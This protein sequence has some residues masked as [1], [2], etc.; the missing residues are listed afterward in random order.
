MLN[1]VQEKSLGSLDLSKKISSIRPL[2]AVFIVSLLLG[3]CS[4]NNNPPTAQSQQKTVDLIISAANSIV[5]PIREIEELYEQQKPEVDVILNLANSGALQQQ[6]EQGAPADVF[7]SSAA[8]KMDRL[9]S[10]QLLLSGSR[11]N[12]LQ[13]KVAL[14]VPSDSDVSSFQ[15]LTDE[16]VERISIGE[17]TSSPIGSYS[18]EVFKSQT[19]NEQIKPKLVFGKHSRQVLEYVRSGSADAGITFTT[20]VKPNNEQIKIAAVAE[21][22]D[23]SQIFYP[24]AVIKF[25]ENPEAAQE[26][27]EFL[28]TKEASQVFTKYGFIHLGEN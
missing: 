6:I 18:V 25:S 4:P 26:F 10:K 17:P 23:H 24:T 7:I 20:D 9:E 27:I 22:S 8:D 5:D 15:D 1:F 12:L 2:G 16:K 28:F 21:S 14:I 19:I 11:K 3:A 13:N